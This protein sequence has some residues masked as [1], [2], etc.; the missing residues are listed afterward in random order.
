M[1]GFVKPTRKVVNIE[2]AFGELIGKKLIKDLHDNEEICPVCHGTGLRIEDNPY[3]LSD[4]PD[5]RAGQF[6]YKHQ[7]IRFCPNCYNGVVRFCPDCGKQIPRCRTLCDCDAVVQRRQQEENRKVAPMRRWTRILSVAA[8]LVFVVGGTLLTK[9][10]LSP[11]RTSAPQSPAESYDYVYDTYTSDVGYSEE[12]GSGVRTMMVGAANDAMPEAASAKSA[13]AEDK[14]IIRNVSLTIKTSAYDDSMASL[15]ALLSQYGGYLESSSEYTNNRDLRTASLTLRIPAD[16]LD[17]FLSN[18]GEL[19]R[20]TSR[21]M[22]S[23][24]VTAS[25]QDTAARLENQKL[26][27]ARL[28]A[29]T[30]TAGDLSDLL[31]LETQLAD[32]QYNIEQLESALADTDQQ[33]NDATV[34]VTLNEEAQPDLRDETVSLGERIRGALSTGWN[35]FVSFLQDCV[36]FLTAALPFIAIVAVMAIV[37]IIIRKAKKRK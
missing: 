30:D 14:K 11:A 12:A 17:A 5:K 2:D 32:T 23:T 28:Q 37:I 31:A 35:A 13:A 25:Y 10:S 6:P 20:I 3:G 33:V 29:L 22:S 21:N 19:G 7:S 9:D 24:D 1:S 34:R 36:V 15:T 26:L 27:L 16:S 18:T 4:D 8:A